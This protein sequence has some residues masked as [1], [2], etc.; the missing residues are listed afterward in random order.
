MNLSQELPHPLDRRSFMASA[1][2]TFL[3]VNVL[4]NVLVG[5]GGEDRKI[6]F[7]K[8]PAK[9]VIYLY[10]AG[11]M[12]HLDTFDP[13]P[14]APS[15]IKG[16]LSSIRT[17]A[18]GV[19]V[20]EYLPNIAK[21]MD[22]VAVVNSLH[23]KTGAHEQARYL[24]KTNYSKRGTIKHPHMG[25]WL[26]KYEDRINQQL[27]GFVSI[28]SGS[29]EAGAGFFGV[30]CQPLIIGKPE[31]GLQNSK[32]FTGISDTEFMRRRKLSE[33]IDQKFH[34]KYKDKNANAYT[35]IYEEAVTLMKSSDLKV[36]DIS[37]ENQ[38]LRERYGEHAFGQ[39]CLLARRL[40]ESGVRSVEV[41]LGGWDTHQDNFQRVQSNAAILDQALSALLDDLHASG[42][43][44]ETLVVLTTEFG[45][46]PKINQNAGRDHYPKAFS[47]LLAGGGVKGGYVHGK[48]DN[49][50]TE[51]VDDPVTIADFN[52]TIAY[53][54]GL[55]LDQRLFTKNARPFTVA[56]HGDP[57]MQ[58]F[59]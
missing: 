41:Q 12:S 39:G 13:K 54:C 10:M 14:E 29:K 34:A 53:G 26:L 56:N 1:A 36:F 7:R 51:P 43:L 27:P 28:A 38:S 30:N 24:M 5:A 16:N 6:P 59:S 31:A 3:G 18:D 58:L 57:V 9:K 44:E 19:R 22:K 4:S 49:K 32:H 37:Q 8:K 45:R 35:A 17:S 2:K 48:T 50:G 40:S 46:T 33:R 20:S 55:P 21:H 11:G 42:M 47:A 25:A 23:S 52:A 15:E